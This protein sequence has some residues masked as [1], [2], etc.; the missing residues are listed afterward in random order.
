[1]ARD[2][3]INYG[4]IASSQWNNRR[5]FII[6]WSFE[7]KYKNSKTTWMVGRGSAANGAKYKLYQDSNNNGKYDGAKGDTY[8]GYGLVNAADYQQFA[9]IFKGTPGKCLGYADYTADMVI[10][11]QTISTANWF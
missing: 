5:D 8:V 6:R 10:G 1:M 4:T 2:E 11:G 3:L 7:V 9:S